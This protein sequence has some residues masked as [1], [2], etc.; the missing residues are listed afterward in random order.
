MNNEN[1]NTEG[2]KLWSQVIKNSPYEE[3]AYANRLAYCNTCALSEKLAKMF[4]EN[5]NNK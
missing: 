5:K 4:T 2:I 3:V 1:K